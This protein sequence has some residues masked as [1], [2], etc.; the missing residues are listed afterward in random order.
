MKV[1]LGF[2]AAVAIICFSHNPASAKYAIRGVGGNT[3]GAFIVASQGSPIGKAGKMQWDNKQWYTENELYVEW[4]YS[5]ITSVI[6]DQ[7]MKDTDPVKDSPSFDLWLR[8]WCTQHPTNSFVDA[9]IAFLRSEGVL[10]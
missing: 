9:V 10:K 5:F 6:L 4:A 1:F 8:N 2:L 3:C 7:D